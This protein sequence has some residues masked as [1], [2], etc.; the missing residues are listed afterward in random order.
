MSMSSA[1]AEAMANTKG[2]VERLYAKNLLERLAGETHNL[3]LE[4]ASNLTDTVG[5]TH[6]QSKHPQS[7]QKIRGDENEA[8]VLTKH[9]PR[10]VLGTVTHPLGHRFPGEEE[11][12]AQD[13]QQ[14][15]EGYWESKNEK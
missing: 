6:V 3:E 11:L 4:R 1:E 2:C 14:L 5:T 7:T 10:A 13:H 15:R 9:V 8:G 12:R